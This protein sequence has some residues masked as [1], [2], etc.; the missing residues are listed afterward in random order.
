MSEHPLAALRATRRLTQEDVA[1]MA[2]VTRGTVSRIEHGWKMDRSSRAVR[3]IAESLGVPIAEIVAP[4]QIDAQ[5]TYRTVADF[6][7]LDS[8]ASATRAYLDDL[9]EAV[10]GNAH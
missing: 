8:K 3:K 4:D 2:T 7:G 5:S 10:V 6:F 1:Q 9:R